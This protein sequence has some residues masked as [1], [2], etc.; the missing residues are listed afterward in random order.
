M[1]NTELLG[2]EI[3]PSSGILENRRHDGPVIEISSFLMGSTE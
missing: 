2:F 3:F 1:Y